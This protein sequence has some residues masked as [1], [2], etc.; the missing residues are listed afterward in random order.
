MGVIRLKHKHKRKKGVSNMGIL[1][2]IIGWLLLAAIFGSGSD[3]GGNNPF[4]NN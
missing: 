4:G 3:D 1:A 2:I